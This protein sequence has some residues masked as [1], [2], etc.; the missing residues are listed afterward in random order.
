MYINIQASF[1]TSRNT[2]KIENKNKSKKFFQT[3]QR[4]RENRQTICYKFP[5]RIIIII[6]II[7]DS[8]VIER[9]NKI[10]I[11]EIGFY[12]CL[13]KFKNIKA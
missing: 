12:V 6:I 3:A 13:C 10:I 8:I 1:G 9:I 2:K 5:C 7:I 11:S 4:I